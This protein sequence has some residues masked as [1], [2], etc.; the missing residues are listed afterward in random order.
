MEGRIGEGNGR[1]TK[2]KHKIEKRRNDEEKTND[3][4]ET[5]LKKKTGNEEGSTTT[6]REELDIQAVNRRAMI[7]IDNSLHQISL[8]KHNL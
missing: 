2:R 8:R 7:L 6:R 3:D 1:E 4:E 5:Y